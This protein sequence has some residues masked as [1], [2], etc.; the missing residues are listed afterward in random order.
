MLIKLLK[1]KEKNNSKKIKKYEKINPQNINRY[2]KY[3][4]MYSKKRKIKIKNKLHQKH[5]KWMR[6]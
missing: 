2:R 1:K 5:I 4:V 3:R 6:F